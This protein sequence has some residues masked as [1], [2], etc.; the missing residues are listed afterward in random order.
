MMST[1]LGSD[2]NQFL[3]HLH[4]YDVHFITSE[5]NSYIVPEY[6]RP[7]NRSGIQNIKHSQV[8][9]EIDSLGKD[10]QSAYRRHWFKPN[11]RRGRPLYS[12]WCHRRLTHCINMELLCVC[13][14]V[15]RIL[16]ISFV[17]SGPGCPISLIRSTRAGSNKYQHMWSY[18]DLA[19]I[20][21]TH[22]PH[23]LL[24]DL[25]TVSDTWAKEISLA[26]CVI[27]EL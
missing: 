3:N 11:H 19:G 6:H 23:A 26:T 20:P 2:K 10:N 8:V 22:L 21:T 24:T 7:V 12:S 14:L 1:R 15:F 25:A 5:W 4:S 18:Q 27:T 13:L 17:T 9:F 16:T